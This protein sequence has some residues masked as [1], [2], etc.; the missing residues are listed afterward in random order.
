MFDLQ[1]NRTLRWTGTMSLAGPDGYGS[2]VGYLC[3]KD[4]KYEASGKP[5]QIGG[6]DR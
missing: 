2:L 4:D 1:I 5:Y 3:P 6:G